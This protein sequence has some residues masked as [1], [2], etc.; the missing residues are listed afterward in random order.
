ML[1]AALA[2]DGAAAGE[3]A[4][5]EGEAAATAGGLYE[6]MSALMMRP[7][8][9]VP[10]IWESGMPFSSARRL[11]T[12]EEKMIEWSPEGEGWELGLDSVGFE[13]SS[14]TGSGSLGASL[15]ASAAGA[16]A[17]SARSA[18]MAASSATSPSSPS[19]PIEVP[20]GMALEPSPTY[21]RC[22]S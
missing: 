6:S 11:A 12:G 22:C 4:E 21:N 5:T 7:P 17:P 1:A 13:A 15:G 20:T 3:A 18:A 19:T 8:G 9:P 2:D 10:L 16:G 14:L